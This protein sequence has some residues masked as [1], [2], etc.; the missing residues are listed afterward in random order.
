MNLDD[1]LKRLDAAGSQEADLS[2]GDP[3]A[4]EAA[5]DIRLLRTQLPE[6]DT[7]IPT[8]HVCGLQGYDPMKDEPCPGCIRIHDSILCKGK[9]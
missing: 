5:E 2:P 6:P 4:K 3:L 1:L 9:S 7:F 8:D